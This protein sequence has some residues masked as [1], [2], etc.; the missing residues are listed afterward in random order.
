MN[1]S[2][3]VNLFPQSLHSKLHCLRFTV[4]SSSPPSSSSSSS[5]STP[6]PPLQSC[7]SPVSFDIS[8]SSSEFDF[9][10]ST[11]SASEIS[12]VILSCCTSRVIPILPLQTVNTKVIQ[13]CHCEAFMSKHEYKRFETKYENRPTTQI[14]LHTNIMKRHL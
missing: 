2:R 10:F 5:S 6:F 14:N 11:S 1:V 9:S 3:R 7:S 13:H 12:S 4:W 8:I